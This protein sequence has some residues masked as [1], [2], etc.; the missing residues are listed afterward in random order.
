[1]RTKPHTYLTKRYFFFLLIL[2]LAICSCG[3][4]KDE[5][6]QAPAKQDVQKSGE[7]PI[8][9]PAP[10]VS[11]GE[12]TVQQPPVSDGEAETQRPSVEGAANLNDLDSYRMRLTTR[13]LNGDGSWGPDETM[14]MTWVR[15][16]QANHTMMYDPSGNPGMEMISIGDDV[17]MKMGDAW[18]HAGQDAPAT[19]TS[20]DLGSM[21]QDIQSGMTLLGEETVNGV[22]CKHYSVDADLTIDMPDA[23]GAT[24]EVTAHVK[25]E[26]WLADQSGLPAVVIRS[27]SETTM[28]LFAGN[29]MTMYEE[30]DVYDINAPISIEPPAEAAEMPGLPAVSEG[31]PASPEIQPEA[32]SLEAA[33]A[34]LQVADLQDLNS[35]RLSMTSRVQSSGA[36]VVEV[37]LTEEWVREPPARRLAVSLGA[38]MPE[39]EYIIIG[40]SAWMNLGGNWVTVP[41]SE[42]EDFDEDLSSLMTP[43]P[44]MALVGEETVNGIHCKHYIQ[45][46]EMESQ[47]THHEMWVADQDDLPAV[48]I[49][50][51]YRLEMNMGEMT[52]VTEGELNVTDINT[53][54]TIEPPQ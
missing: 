28:A 53:P 8:A 12:E 24:S 44:G 4:D 52:T 21:L 32:P 46:V 25:G 17:W 37:V 45:D 40:N 5:A 47:S 2:S 26:M 3:G 13:M 18:M 51:I 10:S 48:A 6:T 29:S 42:V 50:A 9:P 20:V 31:Q 27:K 23:T 33:G 15:E 1:M 7:Q 14:E 43:D 11:G 39:M 41:E 30:R 54:I 16:T 34:P 35:Y 22:H 49:R 38:G 19:N 36:P